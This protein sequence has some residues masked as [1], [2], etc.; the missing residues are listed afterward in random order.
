MAFN[1]SPAHEP[2]VTDLVRDILD[3][4]GTLVASHFKLLRAELATDARAYG[5]RAVRVALAITLLLIGYGLASIAA[6]LGLARLMGAP[7]AFLVVAWINIVA[8]GIA[9]RFTLGRPAG[10]P[11][12][13][14]RAELDQTVAVFTPERS[15]THVRP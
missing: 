8:G 4:L 5:R 7:I 9:L 10:Q 1:R 6:A 3:G 14:T 12:G 13:V 11:L 2:K 15:P